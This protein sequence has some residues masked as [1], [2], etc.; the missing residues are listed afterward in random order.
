[1]S[2]LQNTHFPTL[3]LAEDDNFT[4][5]I[6]NITFLLLTLHPLSTKKQHCPIWIML[7]KAGTGDR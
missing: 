7:G 3:F 6:L 2:G 1:M 5:N 4:S